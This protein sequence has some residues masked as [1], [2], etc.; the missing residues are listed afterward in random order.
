MKTISGKSPSALCTMPTGHEQNAPSNWT[1]ALRTTR[2]S[3]NEAVAGKK[4]DTVRTPIRKTVPNRK[5]AGRA[6]TDTL[7]IWDTKTDNLNERAKTLC[8][9]TNAESG[10]LFATVQVELSQ[11]KSMPQKIGLAGEEKWPVG[12]AGFGGAIKK[13]KAGY[14]VAAAKLG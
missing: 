7:T 3:T 2:R 6:T 11:A 5:V 14:E 8:S 13:L 12:K 9:S 1:N 4:Q 10:K